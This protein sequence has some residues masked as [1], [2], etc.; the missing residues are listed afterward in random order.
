MSI[1]FVH[2][3]KADVKKITRA[4]MILITNID[5]F[6]RLTKKFDSRLAT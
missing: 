1:P 4:I 5:K 6:Y 2:D 3:I